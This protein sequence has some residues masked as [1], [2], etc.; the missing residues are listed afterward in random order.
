M[1]AAA[2]VAL[3][4]VVVVAMLANNRA[5]LFM[6]HQRTMS[7]SCSSRGLIYERRGSCLNETVR[8]YLYECVIRYF[9]TNGM[10]HN[11]PRSVHHDYYYFMADVIYLHKMMKIVANP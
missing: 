6:V 4:D 10:T 1:V 11:V 8:I 7:L 9:E 5:I 3:L 2:R